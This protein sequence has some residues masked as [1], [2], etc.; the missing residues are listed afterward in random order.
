MP[1][2]WTEHNAT[3][4]GPSTEETERPPARANQAGGDWAL[5]DESRAGRYM[6]LG[7]LS[8]TDMEQV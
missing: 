3:V 7:W 1:G 5:T 8:L 6:S 2:T 4:R